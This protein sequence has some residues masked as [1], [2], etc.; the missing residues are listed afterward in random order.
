VERTNK[1]V[2]RHLRAFVFDHRIQNEW[3]RYFQFVMRILNTKRHEITRQSP[4]SLTYLDGQ[5]MEKSLLDTWTPAEQAAMKLPEWIDKMMSAQRTLL[6]IAQEN[7]LEHDHQ[8]LKNSI[9]GRAHAL[10]G[11]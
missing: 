1:E 9:R 8:I 6:R 3:H 11:G 4:V 7:Q 5:S 2:M 10:P